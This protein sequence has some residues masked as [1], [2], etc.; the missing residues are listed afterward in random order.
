MFC[1]QH[2]LPQNQMY[3]LT[4]NLWGQAV[5][6]LMTK[7]KVMGPLAPT[8]YLVAQVN[9]W[10]QLTCSQQKL[11][12]LS[13]IHVQSM[14]NLS[15]PHLVSTSLILPRLQYLHPM[16]IRDT[17][18]LA[19]TQSEYHLCCLCPINI[20]HLLSMSKFIQFITSPVYVQNTTSHAHVQSVHHLSCPHPFRITPL[21]DNVIQYTIA[22]DHSQSECHP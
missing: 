3:G 13:F 14:H 18:S 6:H 22:P 20:S 12:S 10:W 5:P 8:D 1:Y 17:A 19:N 15:C 21:L 11:Y 16:S 2:L 7:I 4:S 9:H